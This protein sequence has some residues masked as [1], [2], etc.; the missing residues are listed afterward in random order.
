MTTVIDVVC[1]D[2]LDEFGAE[3]TDPIESLRQDNHH[4]LIT[5]PGQNI[6]DPDFGL[7]I[8]RMLSGDD[9]ELGSL[10]PR[11]EAEFRKDLR[12]AQVRATITPTANRNEYEIR[13]EI[14]TD[15]EELL[16]MDYLATNGALEVLPNG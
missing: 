3:I 16:R 10:A 7:G 13:I 4:R 9:S 8:D 15:T 14:V 6:D 2:D 12:N 11:I 1:W 5:P